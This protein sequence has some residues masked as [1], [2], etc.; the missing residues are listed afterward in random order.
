[1][2]TVISGV[3]VALL[4]YVA[5]LGVWLWSWHL[6]ARRRELE[7]RCKKLQE[8]AASFSVKVRALHSVSPWR[9]DLP[10]L[11]REL[12]RV[13]EDARRAYEELQ[14]V[15]LLGGPTKR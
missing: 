12:A 5:F 1:M 6:R 11:Q 10:A 15:R 8:K 14:S 7:W 2:Q 4:L 13:Y 3:H 9:R